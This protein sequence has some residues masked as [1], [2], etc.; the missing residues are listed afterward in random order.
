MSATFNP[1]LLTT[2]DWVRHLSGDRDVSR[3]RWQDEEISAYLVEN[4]DNKYLAAADLLE[5]LAAQR[6]G[7]VN[8]AVEDLRLEYSDSAEGALARYIKFLRNK[9]GVGI[10]TGTAQ[11]RVV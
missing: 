5:N 2:T 9:A 1:K 7:L 10:S 4:S 6:G 3:P 11:F 8:K